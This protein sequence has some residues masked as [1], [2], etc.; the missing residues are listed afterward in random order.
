MFD[1]FPKQRFAAGATIF[2][3]GDPGEEMFIVETGRVRIWRGDK[4]HQHVLGF[5]E[6]EGIFGEMAL[7]NSKPRI[8]SAIAEEDTMCSVV[9]RSE[10]SERFGEVNNFVRAM[11]KLLAMNVN[12][13]SDFVE[14]QHAEL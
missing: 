5:V 12:S 6:K 11:I 2:S 1:E 4:E 14:E 3:E 8:A 9:S 10:F 13:L 7:I